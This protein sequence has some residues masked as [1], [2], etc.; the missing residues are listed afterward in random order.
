[1]ILTG[2]MHKTVYTF[3]EKQEEKE[4]LAKDQVKLREQEKE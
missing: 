4:R 1:M 3:L 2:A